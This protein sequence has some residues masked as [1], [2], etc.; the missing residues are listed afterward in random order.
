VEGEVDAC[1]EDDTVCGGAADTCEEV[2]GTPDDTYGG[3][4][5]CKEVGA[6]DDTYGEV[7]TYGKADICE[8]LKVQM[9]SVSFFNDSILSAFM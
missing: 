3:A 1:G 6:P 2:V 4:D 8:K 9:P 7:N 5:T